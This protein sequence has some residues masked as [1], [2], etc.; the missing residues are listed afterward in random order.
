MPKVAKELGALAVAKLATPGLHQVG[1]VPGLALQVMP[2]GAR[3]WVLRT[4]V[5]SKRREM[6]LGGYPGVTLADARTAA[7]AMRDKARN[8]G[9][10]PVEDR[11][12]AQSALKADQ[13]R[14]LTFKQCATAYIEAHEAGWKNAKHAQ[15]WTN[16]LTQ[17]AYPVL[18]PMLVRD[19]ELGH[20][21]RVLEP[22][23]REKTETASRLRGRMES[24]IDWAT[25]RGYR[26]GLNPAR[27]RG[28]L[29]AILPAPGKVTKVEHHEALPIDAMG[30]F[31]A[32]LRAAAGT[33]A[34]ALEFAILTAARSG[35]VRG[36]EWSEID[37]DAKVWTIPGARMKA[38]KEHKV[39]LSGAALALLGRVEKSA[40]TD[41]IFPG[42]K[43]GQ[44][45]DMTLTAVMRRM[46]VAAVPHGFRSTFRDWAAERTAY[47]GDMVEMALA[48]AIGSKV[49]AAYR[50]GDMLAKRF[51]L[52]NDWASFV[53]RPVTA[54][55]VVGIGSKRG[56]A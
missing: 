43:G 26:Q 35:E 13:A 27:W 47:P 9:R 5:G 14:A 23:W 46:G 50:R 53:A 45:S 36:A 39:P 20:V 21:L 3:S 49:E 54:G 2:S 24:V 30:A 38:G 42:P 1:G 37:R 15:Q 33:G 16:T 40:G 44:V 10:D 52:M 56:A 7:R 28:H 31:M 55:K 29:D 25:A 48:H 51:R 17:Y 18:G 6:G 11:R 8:E 12:A 22:I 19:V 32:Q 34:R 4:V 41:L